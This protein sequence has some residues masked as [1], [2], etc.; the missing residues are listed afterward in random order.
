MAWRR[1]SWQ[2][3][4]AWIV[5]WVHRIDV[6]VLVVAMLL[7]WRLGRTG[8]GWVALPGAVVLLV[9]L[10]FVLWGTSIMRCP[11][12]DGFLWELNRRLDQIKYCPYCGEWLDVD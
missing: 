8:L 2:E 5:R 3:R 7:T 6:A 12:C 1:K 10:R 4:N 9:L 11:H